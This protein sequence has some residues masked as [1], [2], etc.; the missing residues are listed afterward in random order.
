[1]ELTKEYFKEVIKRLATKHDI[2]EL[3]TKR[4]LQAQTRELKDYVHESFE[5]Q[6][7]YIDERFYELMENVTFH[8]KILRSAPTMHV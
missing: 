7:I 1:M 4:G 3:P 6:Q 8:P 5:V 2:K